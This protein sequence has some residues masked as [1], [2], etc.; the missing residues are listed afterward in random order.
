MLIPN[1]VHI[2]YSLML[3]ALLARDVLWLRLI[4]VFAQTNLSLYSYFRGIDSIAAWNAAF[5]VI[6]T[7]WVI[8]ILR[9]RRAVQLPP[10]LAALHDRYFAALSPPEFLRLWGLG[11]RQILSGTALTRQGQATPALYFL[12]RGAVVVRQQNRELAR[13]GAGDFVAEMSL[14]TGATATADA[15]TDGEVELMRWPSDKLRQ[16]RRNATLWTKIQSV[17]GHD[18]V[19]KI[20]RASG[21][22]E[23]AE[24]PVQAV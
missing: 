24:V 1:L 8:R 3:I 11:E 21:G 6:N 12:L 19:V 13:L 18:L 9:E 14:L 16:L 5:V 4:L 7:V 22:T 17:L 2:G 23:L 10:E 20:Q 15:E